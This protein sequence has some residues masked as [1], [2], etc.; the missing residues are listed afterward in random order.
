MVV[1]KWNWMLRVLS[2]PALVPR[3][4][5]PFLLRYPH[6][7]QGAIICCCLTENPYTQ[8]QLLPKWSPFYAASPWSALFL[9]TKSAAGSV[10]KNPLSPLLFALLHSVLLDWISAEI[11]LPNKRLHSTNL[12]SP[13]PFWCPLTIVCILSYGPTGF[14]VCICIKT[15]ADHGVDYYDL[16]IVFSRTKM[17]VTELSIPVIAWHR[18]STW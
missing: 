4:T 17:V 9:A 3:P 16:L 1:V 10:F 5:V 13:K 11:S 14:H 2:F 18:K 6:A 15:S 7:I 12:S 8:H